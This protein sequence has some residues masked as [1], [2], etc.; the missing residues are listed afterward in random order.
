M[1]FRRFVNFSIALGLII[2]TSG[3]IRPTTFAQDYL[4]KKEG[5]T[6]VM[7]KQEYSPYVGREFPTQVFWGETHLHT[8]VSVDAGTMCTLGQEEAFRFARGE[9]VVTTHGLR[10]KLSRPLDFIVVSDHAEMY[11]LMPQLLKGAPEILS[12][13]KGKR[14]Y[15]MIK[16]GDREK[17]FA[18][19]ME[20][21][22]S[23]SKDEPPIKSDKSV[24]NAWR[25]YTALADKYNEPGRF[26]ALIG[27]EWTA[28]GG[29]NLHRNVIF[30]FYHQMM[31][32]PTM[33]PGTKPT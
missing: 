25:Y 24:R 18:A 4:P 32:L 11:G 2:C 22:D 15:D 21:V 33:R 1:N 12:T 13:E 5:V 8:A 16:S 14:W 26:T 28:I 17:V 9:E 20:I 3:F 27:Y 30:R 31:N 29:Y 23:L 6:S 10:A 7:T 19:A